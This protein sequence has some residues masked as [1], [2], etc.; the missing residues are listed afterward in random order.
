MGLLNQKKES[1]SGLE[2]QRRRWALCAL[3]WLSASQQLQ[4]KDKPSPHRIDVRGCRLW[5]S[6]HTAG[7]L[8][9]LV[10]SFNVLAW[11]FASRV[12]SKRSMEIVRVVLK[13]L[14]LFSPDSSHAYQPNHLEKPDAL[15]EALGVPSVWIR[16]SL[17]HRSC[18]IVCVCVCVFLSRDKIHLETPTVQQKNRGSQRC[19]SRKTRRPHILVLACWTALR[20]L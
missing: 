16:R 10:K 1:I 17:K 9:G 19:S 3:C 15:E 6:R 20:R 18:F 8:P 11:S 12:L 4:D 14:P 2:M 7:L 5:A 13:D